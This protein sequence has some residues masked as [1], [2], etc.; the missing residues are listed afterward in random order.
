MTTFFVIMDLFFICLGFVFVPL[1]IFM[2]VDDNEWH[3]IGISAVGCL[4]IAV[5][6]TNLLQVLGV[7]SIVYTGG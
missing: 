1:G 7:I 4:L 3:H 6:L 2:A 5:N